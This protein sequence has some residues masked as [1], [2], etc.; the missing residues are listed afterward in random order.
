MLGGAI[1]VSLTDMMASPFLNIS[2][3]HRSSSWDTYSLHGTFP[4]T[5]AVLLALATDLG[6][7]FRRFRTEW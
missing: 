6:D 5:D 1:M 3:V 4:L 2:G 7:H